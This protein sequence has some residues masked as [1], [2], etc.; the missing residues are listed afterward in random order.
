LQSRQIAGWD[1]R[2]LI[3]G[4]KPGGFMLV[5][6][7]S[8]DQVPAHLR[9]KAT[10]AEDG[11][12][13]VELASAEEMHDISG[14]KRAL[15]RERDARRKA[16]QAAKNQ[17]MDRLKSEAG[18]PEEDD[19]KQ[20]AETDRINQMIERSLQKEREE[21]ETRIAALQTSNEQLSGELAQKRKKLGQVIID[22][23]VTKAFDG[24]GI[25]VKP[26]ALDDVLARA[27]G[28]WALDEGGNPVA[29][30]GN[31]GEPLDFKAWA[32]GLYK[33][34]SH[35]FETNSGGG[36]PIKGGDSSPAG[37]KRI[38]RHDKKSVQRK[39]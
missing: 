4:E 36:A 28:M 3:K 5:Y 13:S 16:E 38:S 20:S 23:S 15:E 29:A 34:A 14:L 11:M 2:P 18:A 35:L 21:Y 12:F 31:G 9:E 32:A 22:A 7:D 30:G 25:K 8:Q 37:R 24:L 6:F 27:R 33:S 39:H 26:G 10:A 19:S 1:G 17:A